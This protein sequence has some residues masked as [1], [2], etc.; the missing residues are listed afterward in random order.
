L[1]SLGFGAELQPATM[2]AQSRKTVIFFTMK[3]LLALLRESLPLS[4]QICN[5]DWNKK[6]PVRGRKCAEIKQ[7]CL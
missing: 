2:Q 5:F 3:S 6:A 4:R 1:G 7:P